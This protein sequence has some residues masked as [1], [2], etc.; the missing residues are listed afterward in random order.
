MHVAKV[1]FTEGVKQ[2]SQR[3]TQPNHSSP[4]ET[5]SDRLSHNSVTTNSDFGLQQ[6]HQLRPETSVMMAPF[7]VNHTAPAPQVAKIP[8]YSTRSGAMYCSKTFQSVACFN[9]G[10]RYRR[11]TNLK[12]SKG[13]LEQYE[14]FRSQ[15]NI[16]IYISLEGKAALRINR[17]I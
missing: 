2:G 1:T 5:E 12:F 9:T 16:H 10:K 8:V 17:S 15:F 4:M 6:I 11:E 14:S 3:L 7:M 13:A